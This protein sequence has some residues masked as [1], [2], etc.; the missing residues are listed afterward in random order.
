[1]T[2]SVNRSSKYYIGQFLKCMVII[3]VI[4]NC[5][6]V[7]AQ[8]T[9]NIKL[10]NGNILTGEIMSMKLGLLTYKMDGPGTITIKW[11]YVTA[12]SSDKIF[13]FTLR[14]GEII[15]GQMDSLFKTYRLHSL[16]SIIEII[17]I[18]D[19]FLKRLLGEVNLGFNYTKSNS[20]LQSNFSS[21][22]SYVIPTKEFNLKLNS[23]V[24]NYGRD[25]SLTKKQDI[26]GSYKRDFTKKYFWVASLGWQQNTELG[27]NNRYL[28]T[29]AAGWQPLTDNHNRLLASA[30]LSYNQEQS[31][32]TNQYTGNL[33]ALFEV[34]YKRFYYSTPKLSINA[35]YLIFPGLTDWGRIRMQADL[36][37][38]VEIFKDFQIGL[39]TYYSF[40]NKPPE[41]SSSTNDYGIM[42]TVGYVFGK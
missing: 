17:P 5:N 22:I 29:A 15:I 16:D 2:L 3:A 6:R 23:I 19:R 27:L 28:V 39:V 4:T 40:D 7:Y 33:D 11:E 14:N 41:G 32:E 42:F 35:D 24:T 37:V 13:D 25:T 9:D 12:I 38:S 31:I 20:I 30:G 18:K 1:M 8:K 34:A 21:S 10:K 36:N 26:T